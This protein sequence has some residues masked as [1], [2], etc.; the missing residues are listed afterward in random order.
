MKQISLFFAVQV[1]KRKSDVYILKVPQGGNEWNSKR[2][3]DAKGDNPK[4]ISPFY[5]IHCSKYQLIKSMYKII[6]SL[7][8]QKSF[9]ACHNSGI[10]SD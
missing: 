3:K 6:T 5:E 4:K 10:Q 9:E 2:W 8:L 7:F 1:L